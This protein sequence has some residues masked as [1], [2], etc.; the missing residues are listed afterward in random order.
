MS[1]K[2]SLVG[3]AAVGLLAFAFEFEVFAGA[4]VG[5]GVHADRAI[6]AAAVRTIFLIIVILCLLKDI[7]RSGVI[8]I[9]S[10]RSMAIWNDIM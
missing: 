4:F 7:F 5:G 9:W 10:I 3:A 2:A 6:A 8:A 1:N